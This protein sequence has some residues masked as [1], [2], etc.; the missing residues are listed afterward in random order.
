MIEII[1]KIISNKNGRA[2][3][4]MV[5][6]ADYNRFDHIFLCKIIAR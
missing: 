2:C 1:N 4:S 3:R 5:W 6:I